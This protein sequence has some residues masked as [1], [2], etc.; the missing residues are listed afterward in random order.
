M[1]ERDRERDIGGNIRTTGIIKATC[2]L[3]IHVICWGKAEKI[4]QRSTVQCLVCQPKQVTK[5]QNRSASS[6]SR[7]R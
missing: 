3:F 4:L 2:W 6:N 1:R 5:G 7:D